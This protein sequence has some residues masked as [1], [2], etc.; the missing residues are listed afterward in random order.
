MNG[1]FE[2]LQDLSNHRYSVTSAGNGLYNIAMLRTIS[3]T[4]SEGGGNSNAAAAAEAWENVS[5]LGNDKAVALKNKIMELSQLGSPKDYVNELKR[6]MPNESNAAQ[7]AALGIISEAGRNLGSRIE[8]RQTAMAEALFHRGLS[9]GDSAERNS[10]WAKAIGGFAS[11]SGEGE[12]D[13]LSA[14]TMIGFDRILDS[15]LLLG[16]G[17]A[18]SSID[19][20]ADAHELSATGHSVFLY[21]GTDLDDSWNLH[22]NVMYGTADYE[23]KTSEVSAEYKVQSYGAEAI[24]NYR[25][26]GRFLPEAGIRYSHI[27]ADD[28]KDSIGAEISS[29]ADDIFTGIAGLGY[30]FPWKDWKAAAHAHVS[31]DIMSDDRK[32]S[33]KIGNQSYHIVSGKMDPLG[34]EAGISGAKVF[35]GIELNLAYDFAYKNEYMSHNLSAKGTY[36]F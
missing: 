2:S 27:A 20:D 3:E 16:I 33:V 5:G 6:I 1:E 15:G 12:F 30:S 23:D 9:S 36:R 28:Y 10:I 29:D 32:T 25:K 24:V 4:V 8:A 18:Y 7:S 22:G 26:A 13:S 31:Y 21:A 17:Y 11:K 14:G 34:V 35:G 19:A